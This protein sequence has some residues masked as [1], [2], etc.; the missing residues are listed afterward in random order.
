M[1]FALPPAVPPPAWADP[2]RGA[3]RRQ[4]NRQQIAWGRIDRDAQLPD[5][6][7]A[8]VIGGVIERLDLSALSAQIEAR[9]EGAGAPAIDP[10]LR[11]TVWGYTTSEGEGSA[12]EIWR[13]VK[14]QQHAAYRWIGG[15]VEIGDHTLRDVRC[16]QGEVLNPLITQGCAV[17]MKQDLVDVD[18]VAQDGTRVRAARGWPRSGVSR[19]ARRSCS[20]RASTWRRSRVRRPT[21]P[22]GRAEGR[23]ASAA[24]SSGSIVWRPP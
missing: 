7:P 15:G 24:P 9:D 4:A 22:A 6:H 12:R 21:R 13:L 23:R 17:L 10:K 5:E 20:R 1:R 16:Q 2:K 14:V 8:R 18:R 19:R 3:R 11:L